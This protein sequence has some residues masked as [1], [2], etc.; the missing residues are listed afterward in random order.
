MTITI[1]QEVEC[2]HCNKYF[3]AEVEGEYEGTHD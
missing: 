1:K 3:I 2:P